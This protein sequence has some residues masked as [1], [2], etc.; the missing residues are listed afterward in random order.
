MLR[1]WRGC[2][3]SPEITDGAGM[4][5]IDELFSRL[6]RENCSAFMPFIP[7][8]DPDLPTTIQ[9]LH[10]AARSGADIV[11]LGIPFSDPVADGPAIQA[12][13][14]RALKQGLTP[15]EVIKAVASVRE[16]IPIPSVAMVSYSIVYRLGETRFL[17]EA[18][19]GGFDGA[20]IPDLPP[21][22]AKDFIAEARECDF[23]T[24]FLVA[25]NTLEERRKRIAELSSGFIYYISVLGITGAR[26]R[27][28]RELEDDLKSLKGMTTKPVAVGFGVSLPEQA[29]ML[30]KVAEGVIVGS[31][32]VERIE[33][34]SAAERSR[35]I[36]EIESYMRTMAEATHSGR[37]G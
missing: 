9:L 34:F 8:G 20:I 16:K 6:A 24:I 4:N 2:G 21:E 36:S 26:N 30:A 35:L 19:E 33:K 32:L 11:E 29:A 13:F 22:E 23:K 18:E 14:T 37:Q 25:P 31:A 7:A 5:R 3:A 27:L 12:S 28:P 17:K 15:I 10:T 1:L